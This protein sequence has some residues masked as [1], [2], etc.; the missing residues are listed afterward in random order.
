MGYMLLLC[1][2]TMNKLYFLFFTKVHDNNMLVKFA[3]HTCFKAYLSPKVRTQSRILYTLVPF[4]FVD[5]E[6]AL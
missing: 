2:S 6:L 3:Q 1:T 4:R 5:S